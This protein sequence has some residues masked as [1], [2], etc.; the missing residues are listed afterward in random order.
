MISK[1][2]TLEGRK[3]VDRIKELAHAQL[4]EVEQKEAEKIVRS[5]TGRAKLQFG[6]KVADVANKVTT[7]IGKGFVA[8]A[9]ILPVGYIIMASTG[10]ISLAMIGGIFLCISKNPFDPSDP[11]SRSRAAQ[12][13][14]MI[15][16]GISHLR[17]RLHAMSLWSQAHPAVP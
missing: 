3:V 12:L 14:G 10:V 8:F 4:G 1:K 11:K 7:Y 6:L 15:S 17:D 9:P 16:N 5:L 13:V 2:A